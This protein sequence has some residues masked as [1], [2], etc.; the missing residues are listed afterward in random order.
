MTI[1]NQYSFVIVALLCM[2]GLGLFLLRDGA[3]A[4]D[5]VALA[6]LLIGFGIAHTLLSPGHS[7]ESELQGVHSSIGSGRAVLLEYQSPY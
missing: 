6:A 7:T 1:I 3:E 2:V 4:S 5:I